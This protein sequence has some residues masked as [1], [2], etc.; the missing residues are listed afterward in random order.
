MWSYSDLEFLV[1]QWSQALSGGRVQSVILRE[2]SLSLEIYSRGQLWGL[3]YC[4]QARKSLL[5]V[6]PLTQPLRGPSRA[7]PLVL[8]LRAHV[9]GHRLQDLNLAIHGERV[10]QASFFAA[11]LQWWLIPGVSQCVVHT[12]DKKVSLFPPRELP[13]QAPAAGVQA[14]GSESFSLEGELAISGPPSVSEPSTLPGVGFL[15]WQK[16]FLMQQ[17]GGAQRD[18]WQNHFYKE[19]LWLYEQK[20]GGLEF[21]NDLPPG[22]VWERSPSEKEKPQ[23]SAGIQ[24]LLTKLKLEQARKIQELSAWQRVHDLLIHGQREEAQQEWKLLVGDEALSAKPARHWSNSFYEKWRQKKEKLHRLTEKLSALEAQGTLS[25]NALEPRGDERTIRDSASSETTAKSQESSVNQRSSKSSRISYRT[26]RVH[27]FEIRYTRSGP[28]NLKLLRSAQPWDFWIHNR[29]YP[30]AFFILMRPHKNHSGPS[31][32][33]WIEIL[34]EILR[35]ERRQESEYLV[36]EVR[37]VQPIKG[38]KP[39]LVRYREEKVYRVHL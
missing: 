33:Q 26:L 18:E 30:G 11:S 37:Y 21:I 3:T 28:E 9:V 25:S 24:G 29:W 15:E 36:T 38:A 27:G 1:P 4:Y 8:F 17:L 13:K 39:G 20:A 23:R 19:L 2:G 14:S 31:E 6:W 16:H 32:S 22:V 12:E 5:F 34:G 35:A 10:V 7:H